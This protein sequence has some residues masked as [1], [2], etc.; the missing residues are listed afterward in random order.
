MKLFTK[1]VIRSINLN[2]KYKILLQRKITHAN[3]PVFRGGQGSQGSPQARPTEQ[4]HEA[5]VSFDIIGCS[6]TRRGDLPVVLYACLKHK[7][8][9]MSVNFKHCYYYHYSQKLTK[10]N[11]K[12]L[13]N[14]VI[15]II[16]L[17]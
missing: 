12:K 13:E 1:L 2:F 6:H 9:L 8:F 14:E 16:L 4:Q 11:Y 5:L 7:D 15:F 10:Y 17:N 3:V